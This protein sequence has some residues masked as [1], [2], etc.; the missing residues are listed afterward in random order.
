MQSEFQYGTPIKE[1]TENECA[2]YSNST[3]LQKKSK[4][5]RGRLTDTIPRNQQKESSSEGDNKSTESHS[6]GSYESDQA[7]EAGEYSDLLYKKPKHVFKSKQER[8]EFVRSYM[9][10]EKTEVTLIY[11]P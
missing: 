7:A 9:A 6:T 10:K 2:Y 3:N 4:Q 8:I 1:I 5:K 11:R